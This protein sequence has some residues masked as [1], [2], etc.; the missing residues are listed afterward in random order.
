MLFF[1]LENM[2]N[3]KKR[4]NYNYYNHCSTKTQKKKDMKKLTKKNVANYDLA[5]NCRI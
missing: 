3:Q 4:K 5:P 2:T 1:A